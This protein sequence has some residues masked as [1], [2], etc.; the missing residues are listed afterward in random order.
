MR[1]WT[2]GLHNHITHTF[3]EGDVHAF[4]TLVN[5]YEIDESKTVLEVFKDHLI[6]KSNV[7][8][9]YS[10]GLDSE[11]TIL[12]CLHNKIPVEALTMRLL[13]NG[14]PFNT[15]DL[16]Y[17]EKFCRENNVKQVLVDLD[18]DKFFENGDHIK[19]LEPY[20][21]TQPHVASHF[22]LLNQSDKFKVFGGDYPWIVTQSN[23]RTINPFKSSYHMYD[24]YMR[25]NN[26]DGIGNMIGY[27][28]ESCVKFM[29]KHVELIEQRQFTT[30]HANIGLY[31]YTMYN[32]LGFGIR[33]A[34]FRGYGWEHVGILGIAMFKVTNDLIARFG[35]TNNTIEYG[36]IFGQFI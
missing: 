18:A 34:R 21:I 11:A 10:G 23:P 1:I 9:L 20:K 30:T 29:R 22:W 35:A 33:D 24:L 17:S 19:Y 16:Y 2:T 13:R 8:V 25:D 15:H 7:Q 31:K 14:M 27:S 28:L 5:D 6:D 12:S 3:T 36:N 4:H 26:M 32:E